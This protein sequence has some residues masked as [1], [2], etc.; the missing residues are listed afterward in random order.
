MSFLDRLRRGSA[1]DA[2]IDD[3]VLRADELV[4]AAGGTW[5]GHLF[6]NSKIGLSPGLTW[7]FNFKFDEVSRDYG[8]SP[9]SFSVD[10][11]PLPGAAW[12]A[13]VG[14][15]VR[16]RRFAEPVECSAYFFSHHRY[17][18]VLLRVLEQD[19]RRIRVSVE[20]QGDID[21]LGVDRWK[22]DQWLGFEGIT[23]QLEGIRSGEQAAEQLAIW[24]DIA[25]LRSKQ[26][27]AGFRFFDPRPR[28][29][30]LP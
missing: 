26:S 19:E 12:T 24:T 25:G 6:E 8:S 20:A 30:A 7:S 18:T 21:G 1:P 16:C 9:V 29:P 5:S 15:T 3:D 13:M 23:V 2:E 27:P 22:V 14:H 11:A 4:P 10:W 17:D 28:G